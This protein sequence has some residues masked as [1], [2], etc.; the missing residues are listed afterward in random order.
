MKVKAIK[1]RIFM[2]PQ[3]DLLFFIKESFSNLEI[4]EE[5]II[6]ITSKIVAIWQGRCIKIEKGIN[7]ERLIKQEADFY[8]TYTAQKPRRPVTLTLKN[9]I[10]V[11]AAGIDASNSNGYYILWPKDPFLPT[12]QIYEF[13]KKTYNLKKVG[14]IISDSRSNL[15]RLGITGIGISYYGFKPLKDY[16]GAKDI[17]G[18]TLQYSRTNIVDSLADAA[19][20]VMGEGKE[21]TPIAIIEDV[22]DINFTT[23]LSKKDMVEADTKTDI[24]APLVTSVKWKKGGS[25]HEYTN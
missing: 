25:N 10:L 1:T 12:K 5:S 24:Y 19:V 4:K 22:Q 17:F 6:V 21:Q 3:D 18:R 23:K 7:K 9:N 11:S 2:P 13:I 15:L 8:F 14:I 20:F 16:R